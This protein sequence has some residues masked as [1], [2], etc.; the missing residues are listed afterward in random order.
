MDQSLH[1]DGD[2]NTGKAI[3][4]IYTLYGLFRKF[5]KLSL[6]PNDISFFQS[7]LGNSFLTFSSTSTIEPTQGKERTVTE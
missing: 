4:E 3:G 1:L 5:I 6:V 7:G 2:N